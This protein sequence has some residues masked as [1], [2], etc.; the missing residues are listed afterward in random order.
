VQISAAKEMASAPFPPSNVDNSPANWLRRTLC[1]GL[2]VFGLLFIN[3]SLTRTRNFSADSLNY[4]DAARNLAQ[5]HG[6]VQST[7]VITRPLQF[8]SESD[9]IAP[10]FSQPPLYPLLI[11]ATSLL[12]LSVSDAALL[13]SGVCF[14]FALGFGFLLTRELYDEPAAWLAVAL[15]A[16]LPALKNLARWAWSESLCIALMLV[17]LWLLACLRR[18]AARKSRLPIALA[19]GLAAG[20]GFATRYALFPLLIVGFFYLVVENLTL[21]SHFKIVK[22]GWQAALIFLLGWVLTGSTVLAYNLI[23]IGRIVPANLPSN[24]SL[25]MNL[26]DAVNAIFGNFLPSGIKSSYQFI[27]VFI[28]IILIGLIARWQGRGADYSKEILLS[29]GRYLLTIWA[30]VYFCFVVYQRSVIH[31]DELDLRLMAPSSVPLI[32]LTAASIAGLAKGQQKSWIVMAAGLLIIAAVCLE[33]IFLNQPLATSQAQSI[34]QSQRLSWIATNTTDHDLIIGDTTNDIPY[35]FKRRAAV[36]FSAYPYT[37][38]LT[39]QTL[40]DIV[41]HYCNHYQGFYLILRKH[42]GNP[43]K[44]RQQF[45]LFVYNLMYKVGKSYPGIEPLAN[46]ADARIYHLNYCQR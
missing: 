7:L 19:A 38:I 30:L 25:L 36:S 26:A 23:G 29:S 32:I 18:T 15:L 39:P 22:I 5:G 1:I 16:I 44:Y 2:L 40:K 41:G 9:T 31:F 3:N 20:L 11:A 35:L 24:R 45:G 43:A 34:N 33:I 8:Y 27:L 12:N 37:I 21:S 6:L 42:P 17:S 14:M 28:S 46:L 13:V 10:F 4:I